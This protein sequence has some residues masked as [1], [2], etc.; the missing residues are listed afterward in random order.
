MG[1]GFEPW[2]G[3]HLCRFSRP[4]LST[5]QPTHLFLFYFTPCL[6]STMRTMKT[7]SFDCKFFHCCIGKP[8]FAVSAS[9]MPNSFSHCFEHKTIYR[10]E[11][12][13]GFEPVTRAWKARMLPLHQCRKVVSVERFELPTLWSQTKCATRLRYTEMFI[14]KTIYRFLAYRL[15]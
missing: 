15:K 6:V 9:K 8:T 12:H 4:V 13:T 2:K 1:Q 14:L 10:L 7:K 11:R 5:T 3:F